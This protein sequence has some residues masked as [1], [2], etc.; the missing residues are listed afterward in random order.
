MLGRRAWGDLE[1]LSLCD[2][3]FQTLPGQMGMA[4]AKWRAVMNDSAEPFAE[5]FPSPFDRWVG[6]AYRSVCS[7]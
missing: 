7:W 1:R 6:A 3:A 2:E 4:K 5:E